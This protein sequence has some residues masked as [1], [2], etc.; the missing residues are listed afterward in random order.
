MKSSDA[1]LPLEVFFKNEHIYQAPMRRLS[2]FILMPINTL[3]F[4]CH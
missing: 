3:F 1:K 2:N 4:H